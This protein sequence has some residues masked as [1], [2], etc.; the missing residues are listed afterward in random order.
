MRRIGL[1][2]LRKVGK[3]LLI[4]LRDYFTCRAVDQQQVAVRDLVRL[5]AGTDNRRNTHR[6][7][8]DR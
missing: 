4:R 2:A 5:L 7:R 3:R 8:H 1:L 6:T